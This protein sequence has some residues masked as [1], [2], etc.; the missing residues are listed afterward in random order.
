MMLRRFRM[1]AT[2]VLFTI[3]LAVVPVLA[4]PPSGQASPGQDGFVPITQLP[5]NQQLPAAPYLVGAY[6]FIWVAALVYLWTIWRRLGKVEQDM[7]VLEQ[8]RK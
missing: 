4:Q 1:R 3:A 7:R 6:A 8:R 2:A 5:A